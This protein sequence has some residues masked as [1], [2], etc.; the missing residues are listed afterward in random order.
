MLSRENLNLIQI[1]HIFVVFIFPGAG[2]DI[3]STGSGIE[4]CV[5]F[6]FQFQNNI[7]SLLIMEIIWSNLE[8]RK[9]AGS[10]TNNFFFEYNF[11]YIS[12]SAEA[13]HLASL[14]CLLSRQNH[15]YFDNNYNFLQ[16]CPGGAWCWCWLDDSTYGQAHSQQIIYY[17]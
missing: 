11:F 3:F 1:L 5:F 2:C 12:K 15:Y 13:W 7:F 4:G 6:T 16:V 10:T 14:I 17:F 9:N 8:V